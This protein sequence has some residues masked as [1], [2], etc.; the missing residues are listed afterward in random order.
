[1]TLTGRSIMIRL[2]LCLGLF[3]VPTGRALAQVASPDLLE[4]ARVAY[5][6]ER[7]D[8]AIRLATDARR[9]VALAPPA[10]VV[11][12]R[13]HLEQFRRDNDPASLVAAR[14][15]LRGVDAAILPAR[16]RV[17]LLIALGESLYLDDEHSLD[18]R[19]S[20]AA[21]QFE[22][23]LGQADT[24]DEHSRDRLFDW[25]AG[26]IDRQA[27][28]GPETDR[29]GLYG[30]VLT[31]AT[32]E[33]ARNPSAAA[34]SYWLAA[35][36]RGTGDLPRAAGAA[37]AGWVRAGALG[38]RGIDLRVDLDRLML[39]VILPERARELAGEADARP[40]LQLLET[41]WMQTKQ[42]WAR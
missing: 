36:A 30:R 37:M 34:P 28:Q 4:Q 5:N 7:Y 10:T 23:A 19:F 17:E 1:L 41:Q 6:Q 9:Q 8:D 25:W 31:R 27:Q 35:A 13:A 20:A 12:A 32:D 29:V 40:T 42:K 14:E 38:D 15:A 18:D 11:F 3:G 2:A 33:L 26:S 22:V 21:E 39:Q 24:L 16:D